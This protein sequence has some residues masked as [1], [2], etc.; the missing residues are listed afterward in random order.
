MHLIR[1]LHLRLVQWWPKGSKSILMTI[2]VVG[3][4]CVGKVKEW[5]LPLSDYHH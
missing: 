1:G 2:K 4:I 3:L 5:L